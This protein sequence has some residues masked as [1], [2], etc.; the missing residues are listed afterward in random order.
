MRS[1]GIMTVSKQQLQQLQLLRICPPKLRKDLLKKLPS[2]FVNL[3]SECCYNVLKGNVH[4]NKNQKCKLRK[5]KDILRRL[6]NKKTS[7]FTKRK[8][9]IQ[10]GGFLNVLIPAAVSAIAGIINGFS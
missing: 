7:L 8:L 9:I 1:F 2:N 3:I 6:S 4:L 5:H 10:K